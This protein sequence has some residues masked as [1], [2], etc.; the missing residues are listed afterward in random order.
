MIGELL[1]ATMAAE[2]L[3]NAVPYVCAGLG[4]VWSERS[5]VVNIA[6]EGML[7]AGGLA[8]VTAHLAT[9][10][11]WA[12]LVSGAAVGGVIG[13]LHA[14][15]V[16]RG[17][18]D[19][20]VSGLAINLAA[21]GGTRVALRALYGSSSNSPAIAGFPSAVG[22]SSGG[23]LL[24]RTLL[25]PTTL[26][27]TLLVGWTAWTLAATRLGLRVRAC[28]EGA[29]AASSAGVDVG[30][31]RL[32][33]VSIGGA[34]AGLGG[35]ALAYDQH[36]FQSGMSGG[37]GF[38]ALAAVILAG[39][40]PGRMALACLAFAALEAAQI[41]LQQPT[42][43]VASLAP[44]LPYVATLGVLALVGHRRRR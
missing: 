16:V 19:A 27:A 12:G 9:G 2:T 18:V 21:A 33:A 24:L 22:G 36:R 4:G 35:V 26:A 3:Q 14:F 34:I 17:R 37:R 25:E 8:G 29:A 11:A 30:R 41:V 28:G 44:M 23:A 1:S 42:G 6:L 5:G 31:V 43:A 32:V 7:L 10:S 15:I 38:I 40:R 13:A 20:I 39:W